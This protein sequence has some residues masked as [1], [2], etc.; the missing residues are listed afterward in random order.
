MARVE[1]VTGII[2]GK[3]GLMGLQARVLASIG[4]GLGLACLGCAGNMEAL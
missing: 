4:S 3:S 2:V 1:K